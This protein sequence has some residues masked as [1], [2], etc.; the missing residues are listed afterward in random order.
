MAKSTIK[1]V[2]Q[3]QKGGTHI[4]NK[5]SSNGFEQA[6]SLVPVMSFP[7]YHRWSGWLL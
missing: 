4:F 6:Y 5:Q 2:L 1:H 7:D 3:A